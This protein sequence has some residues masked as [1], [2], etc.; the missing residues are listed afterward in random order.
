MLRKVRVSWAL[1]EHEIEYRWAHEEAPSERVLVFLHEGLGSV[2][3]WR[4][5]PDRLCQILGIKGLVF[6]RWGYGRSTPRRPKERWGPDFMHR[7]A[8]DFLPAF[9]RA[10][11]LEPGRERLWFYGH[12][13]GGSI[14]LIYAAHH[15]HGLEGLVLAAP[16][17][18][19]AN[20][21]SSQHGGPTSDP[22]DP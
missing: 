16:H 19:S 22:A 9:F 10:L 7:Q 8:L 2:S 1:G 13:D 14:A 21:L 4:D 20:P 3:L 12:S 18:L 11:G 15:P 17:V 6:S 5:F